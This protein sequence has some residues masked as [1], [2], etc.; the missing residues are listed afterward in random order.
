M[1]ARGALSVLLLVALPLQPVTRAVKQIDHVMF[2]GGPELS[3]LVSILR[4]RFD[5]PVVFDGPSQTPPSP[6]TCLSFGNVCLEVTPLPPAQDGPP[7]VAR[8]GSFALQA[9]N[10]AAM[11][12]IL[13]AGE[14]D[15]FPPSVQP[16]WTTIGLRGLGGMFFIDYRHDM[17]ERRAAFRRELDARSGGPLGILRMGEVTK[18][19]EDA[20]AVSPSWSR[21]F[22]PPESGQSDLWRVGDGPAIRLV[23]PDDARSG[24][25]VAQVRNLD[26]A[27]SAL[28]RLKIPFVSTNGE[29]RLDPK[30]LFGLRLVLSGRAAQ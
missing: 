19:L 26:E 25:I 14:I 29:I 24:R 9:T 17:D 21:L 28:G 27:A 1:R 3:G 18:T 7:R 22:G 12:E 4:D 20:T 16:R 6:G 13:R 23:G 8:L 30:A 10:F 11:P 2:V 5:L 15:H